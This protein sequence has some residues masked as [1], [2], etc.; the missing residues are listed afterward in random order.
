[1]ATPK[2][3]IIIPALDF[4]VKQGQFLTLP[5]TYTIDGV[6]DSLDGKSPILEI[7]SADYKKTIDRLTV[8][9]GRIVVTG[10]NAFTASWPEAVTNAL[11]LDTAETKY[12]YG[13]RLESNNAISDNIVEGI[14]TYKKA[15]VA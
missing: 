13:I 8:A 12:I 10:P 7:R 6:P 9:N 3:P 11:K 15:R 14:V 1:M 4:D 5:F 2:I